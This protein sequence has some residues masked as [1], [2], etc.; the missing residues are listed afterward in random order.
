MPFSLWLYG[1]L[2]GLRP[3]KRSL[4]IFFSFSTRS[5]GRS[6]KIGGCAVSRKLPETTVPDTVGNSTSVVPRQRPRAAVPKTDET[7][8]SRR[9]IVA[10]PCATNPPVPIPLKPPPL[11]PSSSMP[12][13]ANSDLR[14]S[15]PFGDNQL[16][17]GDPYQ[18]LSVEERA[19][20]VNV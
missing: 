17:P 19:K 3:C 7:V 10:D 13:S 1:V 20:Q 15:S 6:P 11:P 2:N 8:V 4:F 9:S 14:D 12:V 18:N 5:P 16:S